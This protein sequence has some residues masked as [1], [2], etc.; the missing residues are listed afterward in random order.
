MGVRAATEM[1]AHP[2][3]VGEEIHAMQTVRSFSALLLASLTMLRRNRVLLITSLGLALISIFVFGW[4]FGSGGSARL[5]LG[6]V[7]Q[8]G[9]PLSAQLA[10]QLGAN[11]SISLHTGSQDDELAALRA[12]NR[13]AVLVIVPGFAAD[14]ASG[15]A[16][17]AVYYD[18]SNPVTQATARAAIQS[19]VA[20]INARST[21]RSLP[22]SLDEQ[23]VSVRTLRQ[24]DWLTPGMLGMLVMWANLSVGVVLVGWRKQ[25]VLRRLAATP[26]RPSVLIATQILARVLL[27]VA[28]GAVLVGVAIAVFGVQIVG[29]VATLA[30]VVVLGSLAMLS[31]GFVIGSFARSQEVAQTLSFLISFP[32]MFL[33][34]SYFPTAGAPDFLQ[35]VIKALPLSYLNEALRAVMNNGADVAA[36]QTDLMV[37][38]A[39][40]VVALIVSIRAFRWA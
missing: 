38:A 13:D 18:Q 20:G 37:L 30:L 21:G 22:V 29:S 24:I 40:M 14:L 6:L 8:D 19:I 36:V 7:D 5:R 31:V 2:A 12:G 34:G 39:W 26:L 15:H 17:L 9:S 1:A 27:S 11:D 23:A 28:Q 3:S 33:S 4:L 10:S 16:A 25:G 35:P 32:M